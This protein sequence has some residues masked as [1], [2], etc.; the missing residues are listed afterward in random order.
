[1]YPVPEGTG[2]SMQC[3][4]PLVMCPGGKEPGQCAFSRDWRAP[5]A[6][7]VEQKRQG[8]ELEEPKALAPSWRR[9]ERC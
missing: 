6:G 4:S 3:L 7:L 9:A 8:L 5:L 2:R 1:M